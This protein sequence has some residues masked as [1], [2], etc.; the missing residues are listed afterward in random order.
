MSSV[1]IFTE[2]CI[3]KLCAFRYFGF[4]N[5]RTKDYNK[6]QYNFDG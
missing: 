4:N 6:L 1:N 2:M 3:L 5:I